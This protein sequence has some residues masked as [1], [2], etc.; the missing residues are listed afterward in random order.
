MEK[1]TLQREAAIEMEIKAKDERDTA[2]RTVNTLNAM[3]HCDT[4]DAEIVYCPGCMKAE[5]DGVRLCQHQAPDASLDC[6]SPAVLCEDHGGHDGC[7]VYLMNAQSEAYAKAKSEAGSEC[8]RHCDEARKEA[9][10]EIREYLGN[11]ADKVT[12]FHRTTKFSVLMDAR[13]WIADRF[14]LDETGKGTGE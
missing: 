5:S 14:G 8:L 6:D 7:A 2:F 3:L 9:A 4:H 13:D 12:I 11:I 1:L 10:R